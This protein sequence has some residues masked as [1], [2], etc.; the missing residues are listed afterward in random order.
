MLHNLKRPVVQSQSEKRHSVLIIDP[1]SDGHHPNYIQLVARAFAKQSYN[2]TLCVDT[3]NKAIQNEVLNTDMYSFKFSLY[4]QKSRDNYSRIYLIRSQIHMWFKSRALIQRF[5]TQGWNGRVFYPYLDRL[6]YAIGMLGSPDQRAPVAGIVMRPP[7]PLDQVS[8]YS[9]ASIQA[10]ALNKLLKTSCNKS[11][12]SDIFVIEPLYY[13]KI[14]AI[15]NNRS[16]RLTLLPD[17][18]S[19]FRVN[20]KQTA[21]KLLNLPA[22]PKLILVYGKIAAPKG[23]LE[24]LRAI[25]QMNGNVQALIVGEG[26]ATIDAEMLAEAGSDNIFGK[27]AIRRNIRVSMD[28]ERLYY[29]AADIVWVGYHNH[30]GMSGVMVQAGQMKLPIIGCNQGAIGYYCNNYNIG[31]SISPTNSNEIISVIK[32]LISDQAKSEIMGENGYRV[33]SKHTPQ[34]FMDSLII[35]R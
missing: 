17:P 14:K 4:D 25:K 10:L 32:L 11:R 12:I 20:N 31:L 9:V 3:S 8:K 27:I 22:E 34:Y 24:L 5:H 21:R 16:S 15:I 35:G 6:L 18:A 29:E 23:V 13:E 19:C 28:E 26:V 2:V 7:K 30:L 1:D 33:F